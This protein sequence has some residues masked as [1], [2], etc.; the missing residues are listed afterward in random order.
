VGRS[1]RR[2]DLAWVARENLRTRRLARLD[3]AWVA[4]LLERL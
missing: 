2:P 3:P 1:K 4:R